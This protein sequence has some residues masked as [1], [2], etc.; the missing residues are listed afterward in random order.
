MRGRCARYLHRCRPT[1]LE[2]TSV[3]SARL[4]VLFSDEVLESTTENVVNYHIFEEVA[5]LSAALFSGNSVMLTTDL[6]LPGVTYTLVVSGVSDLTG[7]YIA[8]G[9]GDRASFRYTP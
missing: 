6:Q 2:V 4:E 3:D 9:E 5:I 8:A 7:V 1:I